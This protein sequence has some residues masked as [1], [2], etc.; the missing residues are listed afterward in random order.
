MKFRLFQILF[1]LLLSACSTSFKDKNREL[2]SNLEGVWDEVSENR[3]KEG[4][5]TI[6][7]SDDGNKL[8]ILYSEAGYIEGGESR[9]IFEY[10]VL[11]FSNNRVR[12]IL[13]D[14]PRLDSSGNPV[15][16]HLVTKTKD[17]FCWGRDDWPLE[18][19]TPLR[20]RCET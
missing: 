12:M 6:E 15:V 16:W 7:F 19:C 4:F 2:I 3:C 1:I 17:T 11:N 13:K 14:D 5:K 9:K 8:F 20:F 10:E 18:S